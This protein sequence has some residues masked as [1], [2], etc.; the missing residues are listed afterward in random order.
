MTTGNGVLMRFRLPIINRLPM[1]LIHS[2]MALGAEAQRAQQWEESGSGVYNSSSW[3]SLSLL[4][5]KHII[6]A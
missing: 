2:M 5:Q 4:L 3:H 6:V 1:D